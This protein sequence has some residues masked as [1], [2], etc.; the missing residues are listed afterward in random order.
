MPNEAPHIHYSF[1]DFN[2]FNDFF[3]YWKEHVFI[4]TE[5]MHSNIVSS[6]RNPYKQPALYFQ[7][8]F[9]VYKISM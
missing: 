6:Q 4:V 2:T 5:E 1:H 7:T 8:F 9:C 3:L